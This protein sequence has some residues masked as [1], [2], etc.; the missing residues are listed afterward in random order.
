MKKRNISIEE[1]EN[2][3]KA[4]NNKKGAFEERVYLTDVE[5]NN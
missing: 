2:A 5:E 4:K 1:V 3:R